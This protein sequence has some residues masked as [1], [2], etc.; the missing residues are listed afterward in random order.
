MAAKKKV[1]K[2]KPRAVEDDGV[3][4]DDL[5]AAPPARKKVS[6]AEIAA[7]L[8]EENGNDFCDVILDP[9]EPLATA[10]DYAVMKQPWD[11]LTGVPGFPC[12]Q[13]TMIQ[14]KPD[15]GKTTIAMEGMVAAQQQG[16]YVVLADTEFKFNW[17]RFVAMGGDRADVIHLKADYLEMIY[18]KI[19]KTI[20]KI[21]ERDPDARIFVVLDSL[22]MTPCREEWENDTKQP[23]LAARVNKKW[24]RRNRGRLHKMKVAL[25]VVNH[26]YAKIGQMFG[27]GSKGYGGDGFYFA[28]ALVLEAVYAGRQ[29]SK[30]KTIYRVRKN[31]LSDAQGTKVTVWIHP[32]GIKMLK[33]DQK[34][35]TNNKEL[36][37]N[38]KLATADGNEDLDLDS[39]DDDNVNDENL[40]QPKKKRV[41]I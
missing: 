29:G 13:I 18:E 26:L 35:L 33:T 22:G 17:K 2:K 34:K 38:K 10:T 27:E 1:T 9:D 6:A 25:V 30:M 37:G 7:E 36:A 32:D 23:G 5:D 4:V 39:D 16:Y 14:G 20:D 24:I 28:A 40:P 12:G 41:G 15:S 8:N 19:L 11:G 21:L 31:H 3:T